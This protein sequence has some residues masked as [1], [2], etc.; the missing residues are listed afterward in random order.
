[1]T[2]HSFIYSDG[3]M[4]TSH[5]EIEKIML[6][7]MRPGIYCVCEDTIELDLDNPVHQ[8]IRDDIIKNGR[9]K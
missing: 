6:E 2:D 8:A 3:K 7:P 4:I 5:E 1:M 9:K